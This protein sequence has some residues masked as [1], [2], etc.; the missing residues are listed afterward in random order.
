MSAKRTRPPAPLI[1]EQ[2]L[3]RMHLEATKRIEELERLA[4]IARARGRAQEAERYEAERTQ[5][6]AHLDEAER[7]QKELRDARHTTK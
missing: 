5:L 4:K 6:A 1:D 7:R 2:H 3:L